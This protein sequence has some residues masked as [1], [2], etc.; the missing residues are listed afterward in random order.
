MWQISMTI[1]WI[2]GAKAARRNY[3]FGLR[4]LPLTCRSYKTDGTCPLHSNGTLIEITSLPK[5]LLGTRDSTVQSHLA[6]PDG[7]NPNKIKGTCPGQRIIRDSGLCFGEKYFTAQG[8]S[9][10]IAGDLVEGDL[11]QRG[12][13]VYEGESKFWR[14]PLGHVRF[15][16]SICRFRASE[17]VGPA[18]RNI[19]LGYLNL[20]KLKH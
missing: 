10:G 16:G 5:P 11:G 18:S 3:P 17:S 12:A 4:V 7:Q 9:S 2:R 6:V 15:H 20:A 13:T 1:T 19:S 8:I 14:N